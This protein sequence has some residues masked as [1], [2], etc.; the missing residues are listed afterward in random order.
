MIY[1]TSSSWGAQGAPT[2]LVRGFGGPPSNRVTSLT[3]R[4][5]VAKGARTYL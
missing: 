1:I 3:N 5:S 4:R 2:Y